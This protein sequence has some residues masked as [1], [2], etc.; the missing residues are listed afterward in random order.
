MDKPN[1]T[2]SYTFHRRGPFYFPN[3]YRNISILCKHGSNVS[4]YATNLA[5]L[6]VNYKGGIGNKFYFSKDG[7]YDFNRMVWKKSIL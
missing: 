7:Q 1:D 3:S 4:V 2:L 5:L 6:D